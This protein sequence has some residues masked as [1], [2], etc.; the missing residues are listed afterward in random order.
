RRRVGLLA[1]VSLVLAAG[2]VGAAGYVFLAKDA[3]PVAAAAG[4]DRDGQGG[5]ASD[6]PADQVEPTPGQSAS[7]QPANT[8]PEP[9]AADVAADAG[10]VKDST[11]PVAAKPPARD[12]APADGGPRA[13]TRGD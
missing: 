9:S 11:G 7:G 8:P 12:G 10:A 2:G 3:G 1:V 4:D 13:D 5:E 6:E